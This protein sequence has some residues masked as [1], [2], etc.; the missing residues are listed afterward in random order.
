VAQEMALP[1][2]LGQHQFRAM[3]T[4]VRMYMLDIENVVLFPVA[5]DLF[6]AMEARLSRFIPDS[7]LCWLNGRAG[8]ETRVSETMYDIL[9]RALDMHRLTGG[10][11]DPAVLAELENV[12]Y[13][14]SFEQVERT[15]E[16]LPGE[17]RGGG[18][19]VSQVRLDSEQRTVTVPTGMRIDLGGIGKGYT[20][21]AAACLLEPSRDFVVN[22][23]GDIFASG[24]GPDGDGWLVGVTEP[25]NFD[26]YVSLVRLHNEALATSTTAVRRWLRGDRLLHHLIDPRTRQPSESGVLS[27]SVIAPTAIQADVYAKTALLLG[28]V[29]GPRFLERQG[30]PG[31][32]M[33]EEGGPV[34]TS[35]WTG[36]SPN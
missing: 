25:H 36:T 7:E 23:G 13:D 5:E 32:F 27:V 11:F 26:V 20:V 9:E 8:R 10:V 30:T 31:L 22:A 24:A 3:N 35:G 19:S 33:M 6:H 28:P 21:D 18:F 16:Q 15:G 1:D 29:D 4:D 17:T 2:L 12:G 34:V 14:R